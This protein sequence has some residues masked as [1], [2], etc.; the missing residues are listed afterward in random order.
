MWGVHVPVIWTKTYCGSASLYDGVTNAFF[1]IVGQ[2]LSNKPH[3]NHRL[4][5]CLWDTVS[6][7]RVRLVCVVIT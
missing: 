2:P 4:L 6:D 5:K 7:L 3:C 1:V